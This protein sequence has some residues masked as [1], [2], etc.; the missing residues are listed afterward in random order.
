MA[1]E[2]YIVLPSSHSMN[3]QRRA[4]RITVDLP[5]RARLGDHSVE[6]RAIDLSQGGLYLEAHRV[7]APEGPINLELD[8]PDHDAPLML[9][10]EV[11]WVEGTGLGIQF[12]GMSVE[13]RRALANFVLRR[14]CQ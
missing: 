5:A 10:G 7:E 9:V 13:Q 11:R 14:T 1:Y 12:S 8:L 3:E 4:A 6:G 2:A